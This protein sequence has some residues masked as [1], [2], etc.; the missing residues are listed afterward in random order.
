MPLPPLTAPFSV[1]PSTVDA[2]QRDGHCVVRGLASADDAAAYRPVIEAAVAANRLEERPLEE[3]DTYGKA[4]LQVT[5]L[6]R[7][8]EGVRDFVTSPRFASVAAALMG[9]DGIRLYHDQALF[10]E[11]GGG[12]TPFHQDQHYWPLDTD[13]TI[14]MW[15]P[16]V[17]L[18]PEVGSM[19][20]ASGSHRLGYLGEVPISDESDQLF[21]SLIAERGLALA[22]HGVLQA[23]DATFHAGW[24]L[25][26]AGANPTS[27]LRSVMTVIYF[28][29]GARVT[30]P[31]HRFQEF[32]RQMWL[33]VEPGELAAAKRNPLLWPA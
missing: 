20:F 18:A 12:H 32:D 4:F 10:K 23:G 24:T 7:H 33:R 26:G 13:N 25:H 22:T 17:D 21:N 2:F 8:D 1:D 14:T 15:M 19:T 9:V 29:D 5:N 30:Q 11:A 27:S 3:R 28:A 16:L 6:W 31:T